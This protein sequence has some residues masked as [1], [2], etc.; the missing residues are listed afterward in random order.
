[1]KTSSVLHG[2]ALV[3]PNA[4]GYQ[5]IDRDPFGPL[6]LPDDVAGVPMEPWRQGAYALFDRHRAEIVRD[7]CILDLVSSLKAAKEIK[8]LIEA[9]MG[10]HEIL[11]VDVLDI[12]NACF[13]PAKPHLIGL[14]LAYPGGDFYSAIKN[15]LFVNPH[16][17]LLSEYERSLNEFGLFSDP[18]IVG[19]YDLRFRELV[20]SEACSVFWCYALSRPD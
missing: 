13:A 19:E 20:E 8:A 15:G 17:A 6:I 16:S 9:E 3:R 18:V 7:G 5:G 12:A 11:D 10:E 14:D 2:Y 1:M 4:L